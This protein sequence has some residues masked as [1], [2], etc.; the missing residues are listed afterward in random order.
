[1]M[2]FQSF[3]QGCS[4]LLTINSDFKMFLLL[5]H[6]SRMIISR[7]LPVAMAVSFLLY[8]LVTSILL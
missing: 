1:M 4:T 3:H 2:S 7:L 5:S 8:L 6:P